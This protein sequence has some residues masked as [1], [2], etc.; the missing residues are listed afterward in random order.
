MLSDITRLKT[1]QLQLEALALERELMAERTRAILDSVLV[2][3]VT[4]GA[5]GIEWMNRSARRMFGGELADFIGAAD[6]RPWRRP[7]PTIRSAART[8]STSSSRARPRPSSAGVQARDGR[9]FW[10]VGNAVV[11]G[12]DAAGRQLTFALLDIE[13]RRQAEAR[14]RRRRRPRCSASSRRRRW[15]SRCSTRAAC[16]CCR[17]TTVGRGVGRRTPERAARQHARSRSSTPTA[18]RAAGA[19]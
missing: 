19:T 8:T 9:E 2:G 16:R 14:D 13:R 6:R 12:R 10:V 18:P 4:V 5:G 7:R 15:R 11:T 17:S 3:I 1:Q